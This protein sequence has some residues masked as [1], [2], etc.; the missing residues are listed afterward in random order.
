[1]VVL[2]V[3][4]PLRLLCVVSSDCIVVGEYIVDVS[5]IT[6]SLH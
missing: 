2:N 6:E 3:W 1:V 4:L 5:A